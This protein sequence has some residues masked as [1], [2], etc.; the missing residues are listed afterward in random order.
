MICGKKCFKNTGF[1]PVADVDVLLFAEHDHL[2]PK[3]A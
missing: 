1:V 2:H 3:G